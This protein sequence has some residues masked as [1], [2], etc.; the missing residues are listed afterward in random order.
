M[1]LWFKSPKMEPSQI[2]KVHLILFV[3]TRFGYK[4]RVN[5]Q[6]P[7]TPINAN[8]LSNHP[9]TSSKPLSLSCTPP[10]RCGLELGTIRVME[11]S[12]SAKGNLVGG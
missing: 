4:N 1:S 12:C 7:A 5:Q 6:P 9:M 10:T 11:N 8:N 3:L 2:S